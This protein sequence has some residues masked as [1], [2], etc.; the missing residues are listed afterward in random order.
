MQGMEY[1]NFLH[2]HL[3]LRLHFTR[4]NRGNEMQTQPCRPP[5]W[6]KTS[7]AHAYLTFLRISVQ[8]VNVVCSYICVARVNNSP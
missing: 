6:K 8:R 4:V 2:L 1:I 7:T 5:S 3:R